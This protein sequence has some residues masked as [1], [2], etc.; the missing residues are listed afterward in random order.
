MPPFDDDVPARFVEHVQT[1]GAPPAQVEALASKLRAFRE[2]HATT[3]YR[4]VLALIGSP[5]LADFPGMDA[6]LRELVGKLPL[7]DFL[8][9]RP[10]AFLEHVARLRELTGVGAHNTFFALGLPHLAA[11]FVREP[12]L[13]VELATVARSAS[14]GAFPALKGQAAFRVFARDPRGYVAFVGLLVE[15][16]GEARAGAALN[17]LHHDALASRLERDEAR[18]LDVLRVLQE[19]DTDPYDSVFQ[20]C[21]TPGVRE[22]FV[23][24]FDGAID[25]PTFVA[26]VRVEHPDRRPPPKRKS[27]AKNAK[28]KSAGTP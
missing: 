18:T 15:R 5:P 26:R 23:A 22:A 13:F 24:F 11:W 17:A 2:A 25:E 8:I 3:A 14:I 10:D 6:S 4:N 1:R 19:L 9:D 27:R 28:K 7:A 20:S 16:L 21:A 12:E